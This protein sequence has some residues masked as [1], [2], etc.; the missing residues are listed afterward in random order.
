M[1][2]GEESKPDA[3]TGVHTGRGRSTQVSWKLHR[4]TSIEKCRITEVAF[5][6]SIR[7]E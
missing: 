2:I 7:I 5:T 1:V 3:S 6:D 4:S